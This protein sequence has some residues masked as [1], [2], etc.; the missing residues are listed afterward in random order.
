MRNDNVVI[1]VACNALCTA[2]AHTHT[3]THFEKPY[4]FQ[5]PTTYEREK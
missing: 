1:S 3:H 5:R 2:T 4:Y